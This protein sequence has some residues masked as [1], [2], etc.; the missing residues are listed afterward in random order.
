VSFV[1]P[2]SYCE[3]PGL[4]RS[5]YNNDRRTG[6]GDFGTLRYDGIHGMRVPQFHR[7][8]GTSGPPAAITSGALGAADAGP[9]RAPRGN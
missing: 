9:A 4:V 8:L 1:F 6:Q 7:V 5:K 2:S 3:L